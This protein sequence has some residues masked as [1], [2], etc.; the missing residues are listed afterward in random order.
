ML[1]FIR[2]K[3]SSWIVKF[4]LALIC[5]VFVFFGWG[6]YQSGKQNQVAKVNGD[7]ITPA[8]YKNKYSQLVNSL[9]QRFGGEMSSEMLE[10][11]QAE[12]QALNSLIEERLI[13]Q[14]AS[15]LGIKISDAEL[16][17]HIFNMDFFYTDGKFDDKKYK[18]VLA[19][20]RLSVEE[21]ESL[22]R[23]DLLVQRVTDIVTGAAK[24]TSKE[25]RQWFNYNNKTVDIKYAAFIPGEYDK[26]GF[27]IT[28]KEIKEY[29]EENKENYKTKPKVKVSYIRFSA[30][31]FK[32]HVTVSESDIKSYY[33]EHSQK[34]SQKAKVK[35]SHILINVDENAPEAEVQKAKADILDI[36]NKIVNGSSF[37]EM[38]KK[39]SDGPSGENGGNLGEFQKGDMVEPFSEVAFATEAGSV[40]EPVRTQFGW[41]IIKVDEKTEDSVEKFQDVKDEIKNNLITRK[42]KFAAYDKA[43]A[44][45]TETLSGASLEEVAHSRDLEIKLTDYFT[46]EGPKGEVVNP[47]EFAKTA[48]SFDI[49][50]TSDIMEFEDDMY[51]LEVKDKK[52]P[53]VKSLELVKNKIKEALISEKQDKKASEDAKAYLAAVT[54]NKDFDS[55]TGVTP[56]IKAKAENV[57]RKGMVKGLGTLPELQSSV[58]NTAAKGGK[59]PESVVKTSKG[60]YIYSVLNVNLPDDEEFEAGADELKEQILQRK[61]NYFFSKWIEDYKS[62]AD[63]TVSDRFDI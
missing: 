58:F 44:V 47:S 63:I 23:K 8:Q 60:Y 27:E 21:F 25:L 55:D 34:Y 15:D 5:V 10:M 17:D 45:Y 13:I 48:F 16:A 35:A 56:T 6:T 52:S 54:K 46:K 49:G 1:Q 14:K 3:A 2:N 32:D 43:D 59:F 12:K 20:N 61:R 30:D 62:K 51:I 18:E 28:D 11:F 19:A 31:D 9:K 57:Q 36:R 50:D 33:N 4:I 37:E 26:S 22:M 40:S 38:A 53:E 24:V 42:A 29:Y 39:Y 7:V 41:H